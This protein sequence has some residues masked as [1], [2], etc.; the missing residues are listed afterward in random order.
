M[1]GPILDWW[2]V[3]RGGELSSAARVRFRG[4]AINLLLWTLRRVVFGF[5]IWD[6]FT[7]GSVTKP[8]PGNRAITAGLAI[9]DTS[10][11]TPDMSPSSNPGADWLWAGLMVMRR[12]ARS[13]YTGVGFD[14]GYWTGEA[15]LETEAQRKVVS[16][17][18][19]ASVWLFLGIPP[20]NGAANV[21]WITGSHAYISVLTSH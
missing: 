20:Q 5:Q 19:T 16:L 10:V 12:V 9:V 1:A 2:R 14:L 18:Q 11:S 8:P 4:P 13:G 17:S 21:D 3:D 7:E 15:Q 6:Q